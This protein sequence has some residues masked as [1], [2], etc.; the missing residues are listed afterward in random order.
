MKKIWRQ[1]G[2]YW[3]GCGR[4]N[5]QE[6]TCFNSAFASAPADEKVRF[7][8]PQLGPLRRSPARRDCGI[9]SRACSVYIARELN[10]SIL[11][12]KEIK[13]ILDLQDISST[14]VW[15]NFLLNNLSSCINCRACTKSTLLSILTRERSIS[16]KHVMV[17]SS[18]W[19]CLFQ[20]LSDKSR[21]IPGKK[22]VM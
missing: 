10:P 1:R 3:N 21:F 11:S 19:H 4:N 13:V 17:C 20:F 22:E 9:E 2:Q 16:D 12:I 14:A 6:V 8:S 7:D 5:A 18:E 15:W